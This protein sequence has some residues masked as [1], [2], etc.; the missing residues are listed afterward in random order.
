MC[1][2]KF[3][4]NLE[5]LAK[6]I[7]HYKLYDN[8]IKIVLSVSNRDLHVLFRKT[9]T[10]S[11]LEQ[12]HDFKNRVELNTLIFSLNSF[13]KTQIV[14]YLGLKILNLEEKLPKQEMYFFR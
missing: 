13:H 12:K 2:Q 1:T 7:I 10:Y 11:F 8:R 5:N 14:V 6:K 4:L 9:L 3:D